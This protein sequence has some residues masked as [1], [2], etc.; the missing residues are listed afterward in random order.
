[1]PGT[2]KNIHFIAETSKNLNELSKS[3][4]SFRPPKAEPTRQEKPPGAPVPSLAADPPPARLPA[5]P[6]V[7]GV[8]TQLAAR[9]IAR[10]QLGA[11]VAEHQRL[12]APGARLA[13]VRQWRQLGLGA[14]LRV[15]T[16][17]GA[18]YNR[19]GLQPS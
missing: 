7:C 9:Q 12:P 11:R 14:Q 6:W 17:L 5:L 16:S 19:T 3:Q 10:R 13:L 15:G 1:M 8:L 4:A 2:I 18:E